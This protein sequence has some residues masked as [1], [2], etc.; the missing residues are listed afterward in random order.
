MNKEPE[1]KIGDFVYFFVG[2]FGNLCA[3]YISEITTREFSVDKNGRPESGGTRILYK[4]SAV[5]ED[6]ETVNKNIGEENL[7]KN[8]EEIFKFIDWQIMRIENS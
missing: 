2:E 5:D 4:V 8:K 3:G 6:G 1:Y 7:F